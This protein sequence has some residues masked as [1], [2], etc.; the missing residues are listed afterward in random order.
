MKVTKETLK[1]ITYIAQC[2]DLNNGIVLLDVLLID[3]NELNTELENKG[4]KYRKLYINYIDEHTEYSEERIDPCPDLYGY[5]T[6]NFIDNSYNTVGGVLQL[7]DLDT[8]I[9]AL[10]NF[11]ESRL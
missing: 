10:I 6:L 11:E 5:F 9:C 1:D 7:N 4:E 2:D 8:V 3:L